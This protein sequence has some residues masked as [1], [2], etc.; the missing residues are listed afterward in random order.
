MST[1]NDRIEISQACC[2][3]ANCLQAA[4]YYIFY[5]SAESAEKYAL[6]K[7]RR[8]TTLRYSLRVFPSARSAL[9]KFRI[10]KCV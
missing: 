9:K 8:N 6:R 3:I 2:E 5:F 10:N 1:I 4:A 7:Y